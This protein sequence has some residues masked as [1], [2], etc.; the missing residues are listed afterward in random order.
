MGV[1]R[2][3]CSGCRISSG[4]HIGSCRRL[5]SP[6]PIPQPTRAGSADIADEAKK[7]A[8]AEQGTEPGRVGR[9]QNLDVLRT[10]RSFRVVGAFQQRRQPCDGSRTDSLDGGGDRASAAPAHVVCFNGAPQKGRK[11]PRGRAEGR[12]F[13]KRRRRA[14]RREL[15]GL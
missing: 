2:R 7:R 12:L 4:R 13:G 15:D 8:V 11:H 1:C 9:P 5:V 3:I 6:S 10:R 14:R